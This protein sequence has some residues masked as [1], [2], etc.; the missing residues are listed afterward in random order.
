MDIIAKY[1]LPILAAILLIIF[2]LGLPDLQKCAL[3]GGEKRRLDR[4]DAAIMACISLVYGAV[5]FWNL[6]D[7]QA[8]ET[9]ANM[10][11]RSVII[12]LES[13]GA[14]ELMLYS[15]VGIGE[16]SFEYSSD[17]ENYSPLTSFSQT[18]GEVLK[19]NLVELEG[20]LPAGFLRISATG[21]I[22]LGE[23]VARDSQGNILPVSCS[24]TAL[25]DEQELCPAEQTFM[26]SSYFDEIYHARTAWEN[27]NGVYP[28]EITH[29]PLG[30]EIISLGIL[31]FGMTPFGWRFSGTL[32]GVLM[33][34]LMYV[35]LKK[36]F[37]GRTA[38]AAGTVVFAAD[39]MH[40]V[41]TRIATIDTY[42]VFF[43]LLMYLFMYLF[44]TENR[45]RYLALSGLFF[46]LGAAS[47]WTCLYAG[48]GLAL[49]WVWYWIRNARLGIRAFFKNCGFCLIFF[50]LL[51]CAI[52]YLSYI[53]Y[54]Q[55]RGGISVFS[56]DYLK[57]VLDNQKYMFNYHSTIQ[58]THPYSSRWYQWIFDIRPI[59]YYLQYLPNG[60][61]SSF[62]AFVSP[63]LCWGGFIG[64]FALG[65]LAIGRRDQRAAFILLG[66]LAQLVPWIFVSRLTFE[67]HYFPCTVFLVLTMGYIFRLMELNCRHGRAYI[68][69]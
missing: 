21:G 39:F 38:P 30:K 26:N 50:V 23:L 43:I 31:I 47:K 68:W 36:L 66:Y 37:G 34:P 17:G 55:A 9:F 20:G 69:G 62:G 33:L 18:H 1:S 6:G 12:E 32:F 27:L 46:G 42:A 22:W 51:P 48:A 7:T 8:P 15:G 2:Y 60:M 28:Y 45:L 52:Y 35:F 5:A 29:P 54:A 24:E 25:V 53:P 16:Y 41:Q 61:R 44:F 49:I 10:E 4:L 19:W 65:Y 14:R 56:L 57:M 11:Q 59:L 3:G 40:F 63:A 67:Y 58:A 64:L 13:D